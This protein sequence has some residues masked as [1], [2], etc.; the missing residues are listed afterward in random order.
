MELG[1][2]LELFR[3]DFRGDPDLLY[4]RPCLKPGPHSF[5]YLLAVRRDEMEVIDLP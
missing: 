2:D 3:G 1:E 5:H 4:V